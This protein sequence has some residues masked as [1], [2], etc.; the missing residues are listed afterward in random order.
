MT[1]EKLLCYRL[2]NSDST[3]PTVLTE[4]AAARAAHQIHNKG[5]LTTFV[6]CNLSLEFSEILSQ[7]DIYAIID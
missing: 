2:Y 5:M 6:Q 3:I 1:K 7:N 4:Q